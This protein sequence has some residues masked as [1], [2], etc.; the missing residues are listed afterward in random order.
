MGR[1]R[2]KAGVPDARQR[3]IDSFWLLLQD[4]HLR[5]LTVGMIV[6]QA[7]CNRGTF[8]Y[9]FADMDDLIFK[10]IE[11]ELLGNPKV[12]ME[13]FNLITG[14]DVDENYAKEILGG[15]RI[16]R[17]S[18]VIRQGGTEAVEKAVKT[19]MTDMWQTVL[20][21]DGGE[22]KPQTQIIIEYTSSGILGVASYSS[23]MKEEDKEASI[24]LSILKKLASHTL[25]CVA[26]AQ[27]IPMDEILMRLKILNQFSKMQQK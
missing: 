21:P 9:H 13:L 4:H 23:R 20:C 16:Q 27:D 25:E 11:G 14:V 5:D 24:D 6:R 12:S 17:L 15:Q 22:L 7:D 18:L 26:D 10:A 3:I 1:P 8:Y 2:K 19:T